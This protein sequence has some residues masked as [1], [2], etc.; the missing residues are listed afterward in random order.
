MVKKI[1]HIKKEIKEPIRFTVYLCV[2]MKTKSH[3][4]NDLYT[5]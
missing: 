1:N 4:H 2:D 5:F 3:T